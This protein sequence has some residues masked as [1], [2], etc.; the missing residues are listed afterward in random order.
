[1]TQGSG[2]GSRSGVG[3]GPAGVVEAGETRR[4]D[5]GV[6]ATRIPDGPLVLSERIEGVR[7]ISVG[8]WIPHGAAHEPPAMRGA[9]HLLEHLVFKGTRRRSARELALAV[10]RLG[11]ALDAFTTH[12]F[13]AFEVRAPHDALDPSLDVLTDL[14]FHPELRPDDLELERQVVLEEIAEAED[15]P[16]DV[17]FERHV[18]FL[19]DGHPYGAPILGTADTVRALD[20]ETLRRLHADRFTA[21][22]AIVSAAGRL[23]HLTLVQRVRSLVPLEARASSPEA[24]A[25][26]SP[27]ALD[28]PPIREGGRGLRR[29]GREGGRQVHLVVGALTVPQRHPLRYALV[30]LDTALGAGMSSRLFQRVREELGLAYTVYSFHTFH[31]EGGHAG[32]YVGTGPA[33]V[34]Q[35]REVLLEEL[36]SVAEEG[37]DARE[38]EEGRTQLRGRL[39]LSLETPPSRMARLAGLA[40]YD[41]PYR[42][43]EEIARRVEAITRDEVQEA[44]A[45]LHPDRLAIV[46]LRPDFPSVPSRARTTPDRGEAS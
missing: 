31:R 46:E 33:T 13:T 32:A 4:L 24:V 1:M 23:D 21:R 35:A 11:G 44:A 10:E 30:L 8:L 42:G 15:D 27:G 7:S 26:L 16:A 5:E 6:W 25:N 12:E 38:V 39:S 9:S 19:Y 41:E 45:L 2:A 14:V 20:R 17:A 34:D 36:R 22:E 3:P 29:V 28:V 40:L 43:L 37:L 18:E